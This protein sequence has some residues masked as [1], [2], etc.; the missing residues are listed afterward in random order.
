MRIVDK[1]YKVYNIA[2]FILAIY[3]V[4]SIFIKSIYSEVLTN[5]ILLIFLVEL[6]IIG[7]ASKDKKEFLKDNIIGILAIV[8]SLNASHLAFLSGFVKIGKLGKMLKII[9]LSKG[10]KVSKVAIKSAKTHK[11]KK[12]ITKEKS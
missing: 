3:L 12:K 8:I 7:Y 2:A 9:K 4:L 5:A 10:F 11:Y 6:I 1:F